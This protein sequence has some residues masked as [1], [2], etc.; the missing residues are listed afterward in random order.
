MSNIEILNPNDYYIYHPELTNKP[1][2]EEDNSKIAKNEALGFGKRV[3][4][5][6]CNEVADILNA[7]LRI[8]ITGDELVVLKEFFHFH[9]WTTVGQSSPFWNNE[10]ETFNMP[11]QL[12]KVSYYADQLRPEIQGFFYE[13]LIADAERENRNRGLHAK[14]NLTDLKR[15]LERPMNSG[16]KKVFICHSQAQEDVEYLNKFKKCLKPLEG[17]EKIKI[18][19]ETEVLAGAVISDITR[20]KFETADII[21]FL[22]SVDLFA[23]NDI[24]VEIQ[25]AIALTKEKGVIIVPILIK[26]HY[27][28]E[29]LKRFRSLPING[30]SISECGKNKD[31]AWKEVVEGIAKLL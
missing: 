8:G 9:K 12:T 17:E 15:K 11:Q 30:A 18:W 10:T 6:C 31:Q 2:N 27:E 5:V 28:N 24:D 1:P 26:P 13:N 16:P 20:E 21:I 29:Y 19:D 14:V 3:I 22:A 7:A 25:R 23:K 4:K